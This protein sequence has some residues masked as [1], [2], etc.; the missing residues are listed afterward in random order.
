[1][2]R[3]LGRAKGDDHAIDANEPVAETSADLAYE[4]QSKMFD[5]LATVGIAGAGLAV[6]LIGSVLQDEPRDVWLSVVFFGIA[7]VTAISG[8][9]RLVDGLT[10]RRPCL[11]RAKRDMQVAVMLIGVAIGWLSMSMYA[12][13]TR[14]PS[15]SESRAAT[16]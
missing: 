2:S 12:K 14:Q 3:F 13:G 15:V 6:T 1:M 9:Q 4:L 11:R 7:A 16:E 8:N 5:Q 10:G